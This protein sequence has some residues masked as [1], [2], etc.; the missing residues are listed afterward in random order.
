MKALKSKFLVRM[1][2]L[3][4]IT[5]MI[6]SALPAVSHAE[7]NVE[8]DID[9]VTERIIE[10]NEKYDIGEPFSDEDAKF[11]LEN[12][13]SVEQNEPGKMS[14][15]VIIGSGKRNFDVPKTFEGLGVNIKGSLY[16]NVNNPLNN[17]Y[18]AQFTAKVTKGKSTKL[19]ASLSH[20]AY[21]LL[22]D[23][24]VGKIYSRTMTQSGT[25]TVS[26]SNGSH[27]S[28]AVTNFNMIVKGTAYAKGNQVA[29]M[30]TP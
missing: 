14:T 30:F 25:K 7:E 3:L 12:T 22:G 27:Y 21:G 13:E 29:A 15:K 23:K 24:K 10:I 17:R 19:V 26:F 2:F 11:I 9:P 5:F 28:G 8:V 6:V 18:S 1:S 4:T 16:A 20:T